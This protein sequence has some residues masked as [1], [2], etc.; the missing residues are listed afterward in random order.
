MNLVSELP[1]EQ[2]DKRDFQSL[3][4]ALKP[5]I[6]LSGFM[7]LPFVTTFLFVALDEGRG[8]NTYARAIGI[9]RS[10]MSKNLHALGDRARHGGP[11]LGLVT[12]DPHPTA[13]GR[14]QVHLTAKGRQVAKE[15]LQQLR[16][17]QTN[18]PQHP[19]DDDNRQDSSA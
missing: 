15:V 9:H 18:C 5:L 11:G 17:S 6:N 7:P 8:V 13:P 16:R 14:S 2:S 12:I 4:W 1:M 19:L 3:L 10:A